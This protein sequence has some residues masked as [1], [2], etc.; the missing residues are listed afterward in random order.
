MAA[1]SGKYYTDALLGNVFIGAQAAAGA[2]VPIFS[3]TSPVFVVW[4]PLGSG[5]NIVPLWL[6][7]GYV[8]TTGA[9]GGFV[10]GYQT[11]V[12]AQIA[13]GAPVTAFT[14]VAPVNGYIGVGKP[15]AAKFAPATCTLTAG[16]SRLMD[17][18]INQTVLTAATTGSPQ[19]L[20]RFNFDGEVI[21]PQGTLIVVGGN[22]ATLSKHTLTMAWAEVAA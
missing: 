1:M 22:I 20:A 17:I 12:G 19:W 13:T 5:K 14:A 15:S 10:L 11:G 3:S 18:G 8:D 4:N 2:V 9:A 16:C 21:V 6:Q 7:M